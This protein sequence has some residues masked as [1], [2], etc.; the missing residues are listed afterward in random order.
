MDFLKQTLTTL[1]V[2]CSEI[3]DKGIQYLL[4]A[5]KTNTVS[6]VL[7]TL[8]LLLSTPLRSDTHYTSTTRQSNRR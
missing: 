6:T 3:T 7:I 2:F 4:D 8:I 5:L 1:G